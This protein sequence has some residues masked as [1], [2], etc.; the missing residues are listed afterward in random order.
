MI[1][2]IMS[3]PR[4]ILTPILTVYTFGPYIIF[5]QFFHVIVRSRPILMTHF[6]FE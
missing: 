2:E 6:A 3:N 5:T 1:R 4:K